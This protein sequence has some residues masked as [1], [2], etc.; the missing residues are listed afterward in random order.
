MKTLVAVLL[1]LAVTC[2]AQLTKQEIRTSTDSGYVG[3]DW[4]SIS[5]TGQYVKI[6][7]IDIDHDTT[8][9]ART[10]LLQYAF[11]TDT[12]ESKYIAFLRPGESMR[13][14]GLGIRYFF[15]RASADSVPYR[16]TIHR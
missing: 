7:R 12:S 3:T 11:E 8:G 13:H 9:Y 5:F 2:E 4:K 1:L 14:D 15:I 16:I 10:P 6:V